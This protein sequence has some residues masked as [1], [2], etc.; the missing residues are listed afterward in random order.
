MIA[1]HRSYNKRHR[2]T[3][4]NDMLDMLLDMTYNNILY[5]LCLLFIFYL[6]VNFYICDE[7]YFYTNNLYLWT[8][9]N[10]DRN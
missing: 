3:Y 6:F 2:L 4:T 8:L 7:C 10:I 9:P 1:F 5:V